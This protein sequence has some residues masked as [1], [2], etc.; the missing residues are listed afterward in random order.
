M[1]I[2]DNLKLKNFDL[3]KQNV[4]D[5]SN[6][7]YIPTPPLEPINMLF[8]FVGASGTGKTSL[9]L[10]LLCSHPTKKHPEKSRAY[11]KLFDKLNLNED[12]I[13]NKYSDELMKNII[14]TEQEDEEGNNVL[15]ILDD[16]IKS[17]KNNKEAEY[18]TKCILNRR[19]ILNKGDGKGGS[20]SIWIMSQKFNQ[21]PLI[22]R[23]NTSSV[24]LLR[25]V[26]QNT[27]EKACIVD[28]LM[29]DLNKEE[30]EEVFK[31]AFKKKYNHLL[32]LNKKPKN[33]RYYSNF[34]LIKFDSDSELDSDS[35]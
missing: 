24:F 13:F 32:I 21:L 7:P 31:L 33:E 18:L 30:V 12:R 35:D 20:L 11:Y 9:V 29:A 6:L 5:L 14:E 19:H 26:I 17:L 22:F 23:I 10:K 1:K 34:D 15:I 25:S 28:E 8:F 27:K 4:D 3:V 16:V 2:I